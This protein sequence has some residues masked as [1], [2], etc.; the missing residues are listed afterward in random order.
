MRNVLNYTRDCFSRTNSRKLDDR[1]KPVRIFIDVDEIYGEL[2]VFL[3]IPQLTHLRNMISTDVL[4][5]N[6]IEY[7]LEPSKSVITF[8]RLLDDDPEIIQMVTDEFLRLSNDFEPMFDEVKKHIRE[9]DDIYVELVQNVAVF[10]LGMGV[11][12]SG[13]LLRRYDQYRDMLDDPF[14]SG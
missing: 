10:T 5:N 8:I 1:N 4:L 9:E 11:K 7:I 2:D 13:W 14:Y 3:S 12:Q 6:L